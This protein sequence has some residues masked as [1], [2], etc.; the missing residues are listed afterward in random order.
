MGRHVSRVF[1]CSRIAGSCS[2]IR[3]S[4][5]TAY[6]DSPVVPRLRLATRALSSCPGADPGMPQSDLAGSAVGIGSPLSLASNATSAYRAPCYFGTYIQTQS[7]SRHCQPPLPPPS[8]LSPSL[9]PLL[10][11]SMDGLDGHWG[12]A[13]Q[14][15]Q[16]TY[17][18]IDG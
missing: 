5:A 4:E 13:G 6:V 11:D 7:C 15:W 16:M 17:L 18:P 10:S 12:S 14:V 9:P 3:L 2:G 8:L 1:V